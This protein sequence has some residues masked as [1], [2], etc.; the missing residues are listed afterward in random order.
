M[1]NVLIADDEPDI[2]YGLC[3]IVD[4][5][6]LGFTVLDTAFDGEDALEKLKSRKY[7]LLVTDIRMP[8]ISGLELI[9]KIRERNLSIKILILSGYNDFEFAKKAIE[10]SVDGYLLKPIDRDELNGYLVSVKGDLDREHK[11]SL[12]TWENKNIAKDKFL[13]DLVNGSNI[14]MD[15]RQKSEVYDI[16]FHGTFYNIAIIEIDNLY[17]KLDKDFVDASLEIFSV[18]NIAEEIIKS[19]NMGYVYE[20]TNGT[21]GIIFNGELK[22][23]DE[24]I[25]IHCLQL[26]HSN[27]M[28]YLKLSVTI[29]YGEPVSEIFD[30]KLSHEKAI[31]ALELRSIADKGGIIPY[32]KLCPAINN[33]FSTNWDDTKLLAA[34]EKLS[35]TEIRSE[36]ELLIKEISQKK[37]TID[38][39]KIIFYN[40]IFH[41]LSLPKKYNPLDNNFS[42]QD[43]IIALN[44]N[45]KYF[46]LE[47]LQELLIRICFKAC[48]Y[49]KELQSSKRS[50][51]IE[52]IQTY[53]EEHF[54]EDLTLKSIS[55]IFYM[56]P[57]YLGRL[58]KNTTGDSF[59]DY[60]NKI[61]ISK[62]KKMLLQDSS[63]IGRIIENLGFN[64]QEYFYR[65][66]PKYE[67]ITFAE[68]K[69]N[70]KENYK[71]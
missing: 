45:N 58:F 62:A 6:S 35:E 52:K 34:I 69:K 21:I 25:C 2:C 28:K 16:N 36:I 22:D 43:E 33:P 26:I 9:Q 42:L 49:L 56:N 50:N 30:I 64:N 14:P 18:R 19:K 66:F 7:D 4:W 46:S 59:N 8:V 65:L 54:S 15:F 20:D 11:D 5:N 3:E 13:L 37:L 23:I 53:I 29:G 63:N 38:I 41:I 1:Y 71:L 39:S 40:I 27:I 17:G 67:G 24:E 32:N 47:H 12:F 31:Q 48:N 44:R 57:V 55:N 60:V 51:I 68:Y 70:L 61:R 10:Y